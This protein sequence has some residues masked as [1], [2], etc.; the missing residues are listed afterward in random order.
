MVASLVVKVTCGA[1][2]PERCNQ[3]LTVAAT[4]LAAGAEVSVWL[5]GEAVWLA[6]PGTVDLDLPHA[7]PVADLV[8]AVLD[9]GL[10]HGVLASAPRAASSP[11]PTC[12]PAPRSPGRRRSSPWPSRTTS[13]R[14]STEALDTSARVGSTTAR[15]S[16]PRASEPV[17][18][19]P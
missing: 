15:W 6:V 7:T 2:A 17:S 5:T 9:G 14:S 4:A 13:R 10:A 12:C 18:S 19:P 3:A 11:R 1:E 8:A 16:S